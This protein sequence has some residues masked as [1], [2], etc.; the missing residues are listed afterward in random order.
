MACLNDLKICLFKF[1]MASKAMQHS[2]LDRNPG[3]GHE[4]L[5]LRLI[6]G[7]PYDGS[8]TLVL[9]GCLMFFV[10]VFLYTLMK[11]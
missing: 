8:S 7:D 4:T 10:T 6:P 2:A 5:L 3:L 1:F 11:E 9:Y